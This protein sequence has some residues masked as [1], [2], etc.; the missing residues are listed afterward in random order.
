[1]KVTRTGIH[2]LNCS[3][4]FT[5]HFCSYCC[6]WIHLP[7]AQLFPAPLC[8]KTKL[9]GR[10]SCPKGPDRTESMVPGSRSTRT[11][12]GTYFPPANK[13]AHFME[14]VKNVYIFEWMESQLN[15]ISCKKKKIFVTKSLPRWLE[16]LMRKWHDQ[17]RNVYMK[18]L[19][20]II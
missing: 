13:N 19:T 12:L 3:W 4:L 9:S 18:I 15:I 16:A 14:F 11:A 5:V 17:L 6:L 20:K 8:P 10:K 1:M 2:K 7:L